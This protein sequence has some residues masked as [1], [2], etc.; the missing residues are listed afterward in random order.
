MVGAANAR[1]PK[2]G[3]SRMYAPDIL[4]KVWN[5][6]RLLGY[7]DFFLEEHGGYINDDHLYV[8]TIRN[9]PMI[10]IIHLDHN[11]VNGTFFN[12]WHTLSDNIEIIEPYTLKVVGQTLLKVIYEE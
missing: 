12:E 4:N 3:F 11:S 5:K 2:E 10:D 7:D 8:N 9:I 1:F 6:A